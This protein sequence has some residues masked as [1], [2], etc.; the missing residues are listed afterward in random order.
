MAKTLAT[1]VK[2]Q[3]PHVRINPHVVDRAIKRYPGQ[4]TLVITS[5]DPLLALNIYQDAERLPATYTELELAND[6][7]YQ[8]NGNVIRDNDNLII[9]FKDTT[10]Y[11][12]KL[13]TSHE[14]NAMQQ[15]KQLLPAHNHIIPIQEL[16]QAKHGKAFAIMPILPTTLEGLISLSPQSAFRFWKQMKS[17]LEAFHQINFAHGDV[18]PT[19]ICLTSNG[20]FVLIDLGSV[21]QFGSRVTSTAA[22]HPK[23]AKDS[24]MKFNIASPALDWWML[25]AVVTERACG[26]DWGGI[27]NPTPEKMFLVLSEK[28]PNIWSELRE[29]LE[30]NM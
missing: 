22:Y 10:P 14:Y 12:L 13:L 7:G 8:I 23:I 6:F 25:A 1:L 27:S 18:K 21:A 4:V 30:P 5:L 26:L 15:I 20:D 28:V 3:D 16:I 9:C 29:K 17:A 11:I 19:N 24:N 2:T